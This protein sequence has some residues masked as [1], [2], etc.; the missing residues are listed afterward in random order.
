MGY[1]LEKIDCCGD[2]T[3]VRHHLYLAIP[4]TRGRKT[5]RVLTPP[6]V[7]GNCSESRL[8]EAHV[9]GTDPKR[10]SISSPAF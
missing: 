4:Y 9:A 1:G 10:Y 2:V 7:L 3:S 8:F 5:C 6:D